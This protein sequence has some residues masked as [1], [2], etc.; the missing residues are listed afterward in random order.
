MWLFVIPWTCRPPGSSVHRI[1]Q[2]RI[3]EWVAIPFSRGSS[4]P[5]GWI[6]VSCI[7]GRFFTIWATKKGQS[8]IS[9]KLLPFWYTHLYS[10]TLFISAVSPYVSFPSAVLTSLSFTYSWHWTLSFFLPMYYVT[11]AAASLSDVKYLLHIGVSKWQ[12]KMGLRGNPL[13]SHK[14]RSMISAPH[15]C[16]CVCVCVCVCV[17]HSV[18]TDSL[19]PHGLWPTSLLCPWGSP[20]KKY[21][22]G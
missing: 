11:S 8:K 18:V 22:S 3:L 17:S 16:M 1:L 13:F 19:W 10:H 12:N 4:W 6:W 9:D 7:T 15:A 21:W 2:A 20:V 5:R 14:F